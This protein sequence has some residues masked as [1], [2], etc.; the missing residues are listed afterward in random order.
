LTDPIVA[1]AGPLI[2]LARTGLLPVLRRLYRTTLIPGQ[3]LDELQL[4]AD[5]PGSR[6]LLE[7]VEQGWIVR[8]DPE[9]CKGLDELRLMVDPGEAEAI[10]LYEQ[11]SCRFLLLDDKRGRALAKSRGLRIVGTGG[12]L[13][14]AKEK[15]LLD[16]VAPM[17]DRLA[18][19]GYRLA[20]EL[21]AQILKL[22]GEG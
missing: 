3:V 9:P 14:A 6:A 1:D 18:T 17:L 4:D 7:A 12:V 19:I 10:S 13:L 11:R 5:R 2:A 8:A 22:A 16:Q 15:G 20:P 21:R